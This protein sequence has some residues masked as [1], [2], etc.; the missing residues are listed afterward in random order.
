MARLGHERL[1]DSTL[2]AFTYRTAHDGGV[3]TSLT[4]DDAYALV[5]GLGGTHGA[6][7]RAAQ[8]VRALNPP[9]TIWGNEYSGEVVETYLD[10]EDFFAWFSPDGTDGWSTYPTV[11][12]A[13]AAV[14]SP[15]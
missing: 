9:P 13:L 14:A 11:E 12:A 5:T 3:T 6:A 10:D 15:R 7:M 2:L 1:T 4:P 8:A